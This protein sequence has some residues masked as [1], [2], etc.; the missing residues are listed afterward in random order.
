MRKERM[1]IEESCKIHIRGV[2][3]AM[4]LLNGK[5]KAIIISYLYYTGKMRFMDIKRQVEG[6]AS[7]TLS[8]EL[9]DLEMN[10]L[11]TRTQNDTMPVSVNYEITDFGRS[12]QHVINAL[13]EWGIK[14]RQHIIQENEMRS[15]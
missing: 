12:L 15:S 7:K 9:K 1:D 8:K 4:S 5:W 11:V 13:G 2:E 3:D 10:Q 14:Y 6:I